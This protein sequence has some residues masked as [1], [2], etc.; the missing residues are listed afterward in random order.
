MPRPHPRCVIN[1][2]IH[3]DC[4]LENC[5]WDKCKKCKRDLPKDYLNDKSICDNC[6]DK[7]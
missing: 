7:N 6:E 2:I 3:D 1:N 5:V 4:S